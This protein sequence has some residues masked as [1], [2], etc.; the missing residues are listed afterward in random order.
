MD[1]PAAEPVG[2]LKKYILVIRDPR[3]AVVSLMHYNTKFSA[4]TPEELNANVR[5]YFPHY[6]AWQVSLR[7]GAVYSV[8]QLRTPSNPNAL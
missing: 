5:A 3:D 7:V 2:L 4:E 8:L 6:V 1:D